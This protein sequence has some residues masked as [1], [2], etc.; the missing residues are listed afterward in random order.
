MNKI[1]LSITAICGLTNMIANAAE[2]SRNRLRENLK[3]VEEFEKTHSYGSEG[4]ID[5]F[6]QKDVQIKLNQIMQE[7]EVQKEKR[8]KERALN[9]FQLKSINYLD[10]ATNNNKTFYVCP[11]AGEGNCFFHAVLTQPGDD[12]ATIN[13]KIK[14][15][16]QL[17]AEKLKTD[18]VDTLKSKMYDHYIQ[19]KHGHIKGTIPDHQVQ[20]LARPIADENTIKNQITPEDINNFLPLYVGNNVYVE[21]LQGRQGAIEDIVAEE[22]NIKINIFNQNVVNNDVIRAKS[23]VSRSNRF[24]D[25]IN[26]LHK[27]G[28]FERLYSPDES[29]LHARQSAQI[30]QNSRH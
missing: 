9:I 16:R 30:I 18:H 15:M 23:S 4:F 17:V 7:I 8:K 13:D 2:P 1:L 20:E 25:T 12:K 6:N 21:I 3:A 5:Y 11:T 19:I 22:L 29:L 14:K 10:A 24:D 27:G 28:H 26:I